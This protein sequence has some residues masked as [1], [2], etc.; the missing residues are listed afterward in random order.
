MGT[1]AF[2]CFHMEDPMWPLIHHSDL[3][4]ATSID[5][6]IEGFYT[7]AQRRLPLDKMPELVD[8]ICT[9]G[10]HCIGLADPVTNIILNTVGLLVHNEETLPLRPKWPPG[11]RWVRR[12]PGSTT[13][14]ASRSYNG[15]RAFMTAYFRYL[16]DVQARRYLHLASYDLSLGIELVHYDRTS[17]QQRPR[18]R[19]LPDG[20]RTK[21][22]LR[23]AA[24]RAKHPAPDVLARLMTAGYPSSLFSH[25]MDKLR[26]TT[27]VLSTSDVSDIRTLLTLQWPPSCPPVN[28]EFWCRPSTQDGGVPVSQVAH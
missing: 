22:A 9:G 19:M 10:G 21:G 15:L 2:S 14:A 23:V 5:K 13:A 3:H 6:F 24:L 1:G 17:D 7:E 8:C 18:R 28:L 27:E 26:G 12:A 4:A 16:S 25:V 11:P 20:G